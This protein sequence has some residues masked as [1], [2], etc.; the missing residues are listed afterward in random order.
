MNKSDQ[1]EG[2]AFPVQYKPSLCIV[3]HNAYGAISGSVDGHIGGVE[4]QTSLTA[5]WLAAK[6]YTVSI[7]TWDEGG[8]M[9][10]TVDGVRIIKLC[11][12]DA[13]VRGLRFFYPRWT[14]LNRTLRRANAD[15]YYQN[16]AEEVTGQVALWCRSHK[17]KFIY[18]VASEPDVDRR[19]PEVKTFRERVLYRYG[20]RHADRIIVQTESQ[21]N[22]LKSGFGLDSMVIP[23]P[24]PGPS[25]AE[26]R[27]PEPPVNGR[28]RVLWV[29]R[30]CEQKRPDRLVELARKCPELRF[31]LVGPANP[32][33]YSQNA[34]RLAAAVPNIKVHGPVA[35][36]QIPDIYK[37]AAC[38]ICTSDVEGFPNTFLEAWSHGLPVVSTFDPDGL[39]AGRHLGVFACDVEGLLEGCRDLLTSPDRWRQVSENARR[40]YVENHAVEVVLPRFERAFLDVVGCSIARSVP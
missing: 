25:E 10:E 30:I 9:E 14:S 3:S 35:R 7:T 28:P 22:R 34:V 21:R 5:R 17:R 11:R 19:L 40:Y 31:D 16:C 2:I 6:G 13:G 39:I 18:S 29:G 23:M 37:R 26:Y 32:G 36:S 27:P 1:P 33:P 12:Q 8:A 38:L 24:C 20:L 15:L 4:W